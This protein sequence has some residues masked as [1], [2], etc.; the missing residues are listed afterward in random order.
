MPRFN[1]SDATPK[2]TNRGS[3]AAGPFEEEIPF[4]L[5]DEEGDSYMR[6]RESF[7]DEEDGP[8]SSSG[9]EDEEASLMDS[10]YQVASDS[11]DSIERHS[12]GS[13]TGESG[14]YLSR[15]EGDSDSEY[16]S[17]FEGSEE[18]S[19]S[20]HFNDEQSRDT[21]TTTTNSVVEFTGV[22]AV[23][24]LERENQSISRDSPLPLRSPADMANSGDDLLR[25]YMDVLGGDGLDGGSDADSSGGGGNRN[26]IVV[27]MEKHI[28]QGAAGSHRD[29][30][31]DFLLNNHQSF[32]DNASFRSQSTR[33]T[34]RQA[35]MVAQRLNFL[36]DDPAEMTYTR[37]IALYLMKRYSWY[38]P[39]LGEQINELD[40][41]ETPDDMG[42]AYRTEDGYPMLK[43][44]PESP[45]LEAAW[46]Y[47]EHFTLTR[48][49]YEPK[50][51][52]DKS[53]ITRIWNKF[54]KRDKE[55]ERA[56]RNENILPTKLYDPI[57]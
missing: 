7:R 32:N 22:E 47:F 12:G 42:G 48:Y 23:R 16:L 38:N 10:E 50:P 15:E 25:D 1:V 55:M 41:D 8:S 35:V 31:S 33:Q 26:R 40:D 27:S 49:V 13:Y 39:R 45:C 11:V 17:E 28:S 24:K 3:V 5:D 21:T 19:S 54:Q 36:E 18:S 30:Q 2:A 52:E 37:Q 34:R 29:R 4:N 51:V 46:A 44:K 57:W 6:S 53:L 20:R 43:V 14:D 9:E 56:E